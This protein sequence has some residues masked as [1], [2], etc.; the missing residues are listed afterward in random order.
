MGY[1]NATEVS[2]GV[3]PTAVQTCPSGNARAQVHAR[4]SS[5]LY[6]LLCMRALGKKLRLCTGKWKAGGGAA[7]PR[8][9]CAPHARWGFAAEKV[10]AAAQWP[11]Q[12]KQR[13][14]HTQLSHVPQSKL[15][16]ESNRVA[17]FKKRKKNL[18]RGI[19][20]GIKLSQRVL[21][22]SKIKPLGLGAAGAAP[23]G[24]APR[25]VV[26]GVR[27]WRSCPMCGPH[28]PVLLS[29]P[30]PD[31][32]S[33]RSGAQKCFA[34][35]GALLS[36]RSEVASSCWRATERPLYEKVETGSFTLSTVLHRIYVPWKHPRRQIEVVFQ[37]TCPTG[38]RLGAPAP[39]RAPPPR[40]RIA[41]RCCR[42]GP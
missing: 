42:L 39:R 1:G 5:S 32:A 37:V 41:P 19:S 24:T 30:K 13:H 12:Q 18:R 22:K 29:P 38:A 23:A 25:A 40:V 8:G 4:Y 35:S 2:W 27:R 34:P 33:K 14:H 11:Q 21:K 7:C 36:K 15:N 9:T 17:A 31:F 10:A 3:N 16:A 6:T 26:L 28:A 20:L